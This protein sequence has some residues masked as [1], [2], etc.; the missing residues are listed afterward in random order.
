MTVLLVGLILFLGAHTTRVAAPG[1]RAATIARIGEGPW[2]G[3]YSLVSLL[4]LALIV[5]GYGL[6]R[7][8]PVEIWTPPVWGRHLGA[9]LMLV[10]SVVFA[11]SQIRGNHIAAALKHPMLIG[12]ALFAAAHLMANGTAADLALFGGL[13]V[14]SLV[15]LVSALGRGGPPAPPA[16]WTRTGL[17]ALVG[18][19]FF[20]AM[21]YGLHVWLFG[22]QPLPIG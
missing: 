9:T 14:W 5:W 13:L 18:V 6:A 7:Q 21:V 20:G 11:A 22:V 15:T 10:S 16:N 8:A 4:G 12:A 3:V 1:W 17:V 2:K 19:A